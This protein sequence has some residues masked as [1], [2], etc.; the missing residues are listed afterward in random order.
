MFACIVNQALYSILNHDIEINIDIDKN[1]IKNHDIDF[2]N[3]DIDIEN[4]DNLPSQDL[5]CQ[6]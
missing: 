6:N 1:D 2:K 5:E 4:H 3:D